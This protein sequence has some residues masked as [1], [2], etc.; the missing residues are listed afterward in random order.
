MNSEIIALTFRGIRRRLKSILRSMVLVVLAFTFVTGVL[1]LQ[2]NMSNWQKADNKKHFG[3]W[4]VMYR[5][6]QPRENESIKNH[7]YTGNVYTAKTVTSVKDRT[8]SSDIMIGTMSDGFISM[9]SIELEK[10]KMPDNDNEAAIDRNSLIRLGQGTDIGDNITLNDKEYT[11]CGIMNSYTNVW[12]DGKK[13]PGIIVT[14]N[15]ADNI[16]TDETYIYAY[17]LQSF[18]DEQDYSSIAENLRKES[19]LRFNFTYNSNVYDYKPWGHAKVNNYI[20]VFIMLVGITIISYQITMYN[21]TRKNVRFIQRCLGADKGQI[22]FMTLTENIFILLISAVIGFGIASG[23][24][25]VIQALIKYFKNVSFFSI[26]QYTLIRII[27]TLVIAVAVS[28]L[29]GIITDRLSSLNRKK[30]TYNFK[31]VMTEKTFVKTTAKRFKWSDGCFQNIVIRV[32]SL[33]MAVITVVCAVNCII[34]YREYLRITDKPDIVGYAVKETP[35]SYTVYYD[36]TASLVKKGDVYTA[37]Q[38]EKKIPDTWEY[39]PFQ[40]HSISEYY[41]NDVKFGES[42][43]YRNISD[44]VLNYLKN[45]DGVDDI[46]MGYYETARTFTWTGIN[47]DNV[48]NGVSLARSLKSGGADKKYIFAAG[49]VEPEEDIY[50]SLNDYAGENLDYDGF[51]EGSEVVVFLDVNNSGVYDDSM[52]D[53]VTLKLHNY[54]MVLERN[55]SYESGDEY[56]NAYSKLLEETIDGYEGQTDTQSIKDYI[57]K[58]ITDQQITEILDVYAETHDNAYI[59]NIY[60][61]YK[62]GDISKEQLLDASGSDEYYSGVWRSIISQEWWYSQYGFYTYL[63]PAASTK[64]VKVVKVTD[65]IKE[66]FKYIIPEFGQYTVIG[67]T[68]LLQNALDSQNELIKKYLFLDELPD[69]MKLKMN[70]NRINIKYNLGSSVMA[71]DNVVSSYLGSAGFAYTSYS[72]ENNQMRQKTIEALMT[73]G[74]TG[75]AAIVI[76]L[77]VSTIILKGRLE[78]YTERIKLLINTGAERDKIVKICMYEC[79]RQSMWFIVLMPLELLICLVMVRRFV[80]QL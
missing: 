75:I 1:L 29:A 36:Y 57:C 7:P 10:G 37:E 70:P 50:N 21:K 26:G 23:T 34:A 41:F 52:K 30:Q 38:I 80:K 9:G 78:R 48:G 27:L 59:M 58:N 20:Y 32:F 31:N 39:S 43:M 25:Y 61:R 22:I 12:N 42:C 44:D 74:I 67:S 47:T 53:G 76:Y 63:V 5:S 46:T 24:G 56:I 33:A 13:L 16:A 40:N 35:R 4:F 71:T 68:Q 14:E 65:E 15:E 2:E 6:K 69:Y 62:A 49:Y 64:V 17:S 55:D 66:K 51:K 79:I 19:G 77:M 18:L 73:Y 60:N 54:E 11:L 8:N 28:F 45:I 3:D 72:D